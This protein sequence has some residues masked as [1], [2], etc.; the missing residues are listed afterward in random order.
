M[1]DINNYVIAISELLSREIIAY[2]TLT[3]MVVVPGICLCL[4]F[5]KYNM[6]PNKKKAR[7]IHIFNH[8]LP[9]SNQNFE[10]DDSVYDNIN[11]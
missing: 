1:K 5:Y 2:Y 10:I 7:C 6:L 3:L 9:K 8:S 4:M 11:D